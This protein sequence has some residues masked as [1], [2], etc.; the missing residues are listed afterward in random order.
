M[1]LAHRRRVPRSR[2]RRNSWLT[3]GRPAGS[4][5]LPAST[6]HSMVTAGAIEVCCTS[7]TA[8]FASASRVGESPRRSSIATPLLLRLEPADRAGLAGQPPSRHVADLLCGHTIDARL[9]A[10]EELRADDRVEVAELMRDVRDAIVLEHE[11]GTQLLAS[12]D[13]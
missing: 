10:G 4:Q 8:P 7:R 5:R 9:Q 1:A 6:A 12:A 3:P 2:P 11:P 13:R